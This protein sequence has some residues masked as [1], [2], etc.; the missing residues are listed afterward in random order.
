M[1]RKKQKR[2]KIWLSL[3]A[4][5]LIILISI[6]NISFNSGVLEKKILPAKVIVG[7][8]YGFDLNSSALIFGMLMPGGSSSRSI[9]L[10]NKYN[11]KIKVNIYSEGDIK[12]FILVSEN[13]FILKENETK[14]ISF[15]VNA[16]LDAHFGTYEGKVYIIITK[17]KSI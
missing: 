11:Q 14:S 8:M 13:N 2:N 17:S 7:D 16:P 5:I 9:N 10:E 12:K 3:A 1:L 4:L 15:S 6:V